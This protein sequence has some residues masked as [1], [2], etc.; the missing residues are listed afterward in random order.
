MVA[1]F[2]S[3]D[4]GWLRSPDG[5]K[6]ACNLFKAGKGRDGYYTNEEIIEQAE[7]AMEILEEHFPNEQHC[8]VYN[9]ATTHLKR[10]D[11]A[12][13]ASK[14]P[15]DTPKEGSNW[16]V[17]TTVI[18]ENGKPVYQ[19]DG[20]LLKTKVRMA[21]G[22]Y[23]GQ[24]QEF[25]YLEG[26]VREGVFKGMAV[27]CEERGFEGCTGTKGK[28]AACADFKLGYVAA[29]KPDCCCRRI[30]Y[31]HPDFVNVKSQLENVCNSRGFQVLF[32]PKFHCELNFIEQC[33][34]YSKQVYRRYPASTKEEDLEKNVLSSLE[35]VPLESM[36][37]CARD[38]N[39]PTFT[40]NAH[41]NKG[42]QRDLVIL[43]MHIDMGLMESRLRGQVKNSRDIA[44][45]LRA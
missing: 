28:R 41:H 40:T 37:R 45:C 36:R 17:E 44:Y 38:V 31:T 21:D 3:A 19:P 5:K 42:L 9:N 1:D 30:L 18:G 16:G 20:A 43:W 27:I 12:L 4:Y 10:E 24:P 39:R 7:K 22:I 13:S 11:N 26:H 33:W 32:L 8:L 2:V 15:K 14:M 25:Y 23:K 29:S 6:E 35:S 34:G